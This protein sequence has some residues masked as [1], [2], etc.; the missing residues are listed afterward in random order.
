[1]TK[2]DLFTCEWFDESIEAYLDG[3]LDAEALAAFEVHLA[4]CAGCAAELESAG[5]ITVSLRALPRL[6][7]PPPVIARVL[8]TAREEVGGRATGDHPWRWPAALRGR[9]ALA[10]L[11]AALLVAI[12]VLATLGPAVD[13]RPRGLAANDPAVVR[14]TLETK[15]A[16]AHFARANRRVGRGLSEDLLRE[17][18]VRPAVRSLIRS[19]EP[20]AGGAPDEAFPASE[21]G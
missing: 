17:R 19:P 21:R 9:P 20:E 4:E 2:S 5:R 7:A 15:L 13:D 1:M 8:A 6:E 14:A 18:V 11:G 12:A 3:E 16:L 10:A